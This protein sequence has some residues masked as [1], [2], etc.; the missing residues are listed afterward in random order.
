M[1]QTVR[2]LVPALALAVLTSGA[3][4]AQD[5][6]CPYGA[7]NTITGNYTSAYTTSVIPSADVNP[8]GSATSAVGASAT[9][10]FTRRPAGRNPVPVGPVETDPYEEEKCEICVAVRVQTGDDSWEHVAQ[11]CGLWSDAQAHDLM[12]RIGRC[13]LI[14]PAFEAVGNYYGPNVP[15]RADAVWTSPCPNTK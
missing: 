15:I 2:L 4:W 14:V 5:D 9:R 11:V 6:T 13:G 3:A 8:I 10:T 12:F 7:V 1:S